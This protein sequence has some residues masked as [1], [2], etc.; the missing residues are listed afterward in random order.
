MIGWWS[1]LWILPSNFISPRYVRFVRIFLRPLIESEKFLD[2]EFRE[3]FLARNVLNSEWTRTA[4]SF[5]I[6]LP[7]W[8]S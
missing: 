1:P 7:F 3:Y 5:G 8:T 2:R 6:R 4:S